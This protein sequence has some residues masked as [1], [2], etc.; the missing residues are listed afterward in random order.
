MGICPTVSHAVK[1][2]LCSINPHLEARWDRRLERWEVWFNDKIKEPY[3]ISVS[4]NHIDK[5]T[6]EEVRH[7]FWFSQHLKHNM[8]DMQ[9]EA[10]YARE[11][12]YEKNLDDFTEVSKEAEPM[13]R[14][15]VDA[16]T[17]SHGKSK[18]MFA[19]IGEGK[20]V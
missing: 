18:T 12:R 13:I 6:I 11:K 7:A 4:K 15:L 8:V 10:E 1:H 9:N 5:R 19:G 16:G 17:S 2:E 3:I 20:S 14:S